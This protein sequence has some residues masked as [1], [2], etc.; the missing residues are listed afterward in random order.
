MMERDYEAEAALREHGFKDP[1][2]FISCQR[3]LE[4][5]PFPRVMRALLKTLENV[6]G[7][8]VDIEF[9]V[10]TDE[11]GDFVVNLLQCRPL[12]MGQAAGIVD[13]PS[14]PEGELFFDLVRSSMGP[15]S[16]TDI[17]AVVLIDPRGYRDLPYARKPQT[18]AAV[19]QIN[20]YYKNSGKRL[21]LLAPGRIGTSS[22]EL[23]VP[24][25]LP[26]SPASQASARYRLPAT[27]S[28]R[29]SAMAATCSRIWWRRTSSTAPSG[30]TSARSPTS[31]SILTA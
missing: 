19:G 30:T 9:A 1:V 17:D 2:W 8:P 24:C 22:P 14:L 12:Y 27:A 23:G 15:S 10:N 5:S 31:R 4:E 11:Q 18:A 29:N 28:C 13:P 25:V 3:L 7:T 20:R 16:S 21:L 26:T 6:Y